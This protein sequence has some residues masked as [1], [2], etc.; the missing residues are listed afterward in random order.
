MSL[1]DEI[2]SGCGVSADFVRRVAVSATHRYKRYYIAKR[3][4]GRRLICQPAREVKLLQYWLN[5]NLFRLLP[6]HD[7]ATA[8]RVGSSIRKNAAI[9]Q[10]KHFLLKIDFH[11]FFPSIGSSDIL[12]LLSKPMILERV[13]RDED[14]QLISRLVC[15]DGKLTIGAPTS[16]IL[17]NAVMYDFDRLWFERC[18][19]QGI[20]YSRYADDVYFSTDRPNV[21]SGVLAELERD[22]TERESPRLRLNRKKTAFTSPKRRRTVTG[23]VI[24][25]ANSISLGRH[26][27]REIKALIHKVSIGVLEDAKQNALRGLIAFANSIEPAFIES[28]RRKYPSVADSFLTFKSKSR[29]RAAAAGNK[30][31]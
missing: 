16:P 3:S 8:Y 9:H 19:L 29:V 4:G 22:L 5:E 18:L 21:L 27:K 31:L 1:A 14:L 26:K 11:E 6:V 25:S 28:L 13:V 23:L 15:L 2:A 12:S 30:D 24:S 17:S 20:N 10:H 7:S